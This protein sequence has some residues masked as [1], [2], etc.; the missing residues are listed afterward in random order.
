MKPHPDHFKLTTTGEAYAGDHLLVEYWG[1]QNLA[2]TE[3]IREALELS[4]SAAAA[5]LI[6]SHCHRFGDGGGVLSEPC[7]P[8]IIVVNTTRDLAMGRRRINGLVPS[9]KSHDS[10]QNKNCTD[11]NIFHRKLLFNQTSVYFD[12]HSVTKLTALFRGCL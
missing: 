3:L 9:I 7:D 12:G 11:C 1:A 8:G 2:D 4:A 5:T 10:Q 6:H